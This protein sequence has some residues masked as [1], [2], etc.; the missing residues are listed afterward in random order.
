M[1]TIKRPIYLLIALAMIAATLPAAAAPT[2]GDHPAFD[3]LERIEAFVANAWAFTAQR[4]GPDGSPVIGDRSGVE[5][6]DAVAPIGAE[7]SPVG[8]AVPPESEPTA[9]G[10]SG[11]GGA[12]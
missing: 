11:P 5:R 2:H 1:K 8:G 9:P 7:I 4:I 6:A 3:L 12:S 10:G